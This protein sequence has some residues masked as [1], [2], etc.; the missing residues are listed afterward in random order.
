MHSIY[1]HFEIRK[2]KEF[3]INNDKKKSISWKMKLFKSISKTYI[4]CKKKKKRKNVYS[5]FYFNRL[6]SSK[7]SRKFCSLTRDSR[8]VKYRNNRKSGVFNYQKKPHDRY[9]VE[10]KISARVILFVECRSIGCNR[11]L[12]EHRFVWSAEQ[13]PFFFFFPPPI[14][15]NPYQRASLKQ[16]SESVTA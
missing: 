5:E 8:Q 6:L 9:P 15:V 2:K 13:S 1:F 14:H 16:P 4:Y 7:K 11:G 3:L 10:N 12:V